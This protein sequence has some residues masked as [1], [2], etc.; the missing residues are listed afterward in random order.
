[1]ERFKRF[2]TGILLMAMM[3]LISMAQGTARL[4]VI[5]N[6]ADPAASE[7]DVYVNGNLLLDNFAF[8]TATPFIDVPAGVTVNIGVAPGNSTSVNDT[9]RN[10]PVVFAD[11]GTYVAIANG[12]LDPNGFEAN[13]D[14]ISTA[15]TL[16][17]KDMARETG[18]DANNVDFFVVHGSTDAPTVDVIARGVATLVNDAPYGGI[19][20]YISVP[21]ASYVL[22]VTP[23]NDN[24]TV[25][26][27]FVAD[28]SSL[29]GGSAVV[30]ASGFLSPDNDQNGASFGIFAALPNGTVVEFPNETTLGLEKDGN[31]LS[32]KFVLEQNYPNPFNP[33]TTIS[34]NIPF[35]SRVTLTVYNLVGQAVATLVEGNLSAG[36]YKVVLDA[37][38]LPS[39]TYLYQLKT[40]YQTITRKMVLLK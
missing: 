34:F 20:D 21:A 11:G 15:F 8:R 35:S 5:H 2:Y 4:Q 3:T 10:F 38:N 14:G 33:T 30:F 22:D 13:P 7:V 31:S 16:F 17:L 25:V 26:A 19:T 39:G 23:A 40:D 6:A 1:M 37:A 12:V 36:N 18:T 32:T 29:G 24:N 9:L 27:S 28:L